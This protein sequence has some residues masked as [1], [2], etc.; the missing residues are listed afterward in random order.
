[1]ISPDRED[2]HI[3]SMFSE[4]VQWPFDLSGKGLV[5]LAARVNLAESSVWSWFLKACE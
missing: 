2:L 5:S 1:M 4:H 3:P